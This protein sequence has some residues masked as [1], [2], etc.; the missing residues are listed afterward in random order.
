MLPINNSINKLTLLFTT[1]PSHAVVLTEFCSETNETH[2]SFFYVVG[3][4][5]CVVRCLKTLWNSLSISSQEKCRVIPIKRKSVTI[6]YSCEICICTN[7][8]HGCARLIRTFLAV[9]WCYFRV[10]SL[11]FACVSTWLTERLLPAKRGNYATKGCDISQY[12]A[13]KTVNASLISYRN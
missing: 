9:K 11:M 12:F 2:S 10:I 7:F 1:V 6:R 4:C 8:L 13:I 3:A 5:I